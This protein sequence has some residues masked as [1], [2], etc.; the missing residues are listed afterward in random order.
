VAYDE[1]D[2]TF[3]SLK[4]GSKKKSIRIK[5]AEKIL[6]ESGADIAKISCEGSEIALLGVRNEVL[7][8]IPN[9][10]IETHSQ[11]IRDSLLRKFASSGFETS[12]TRLIWAKS[13]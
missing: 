9:Y 4:S 2:P 11:N 1:I 3:G 10:V 5:S 12:K 7:G 13:L 6:N 8:K